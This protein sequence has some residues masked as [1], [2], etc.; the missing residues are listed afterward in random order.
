MISWRRRT[1]CGFIGT[2]GGGKTSKGG[3]YRQYFTF[4]IVIPTLD[5]TTS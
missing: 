3:S 4:I 1:V 5:F 2:S